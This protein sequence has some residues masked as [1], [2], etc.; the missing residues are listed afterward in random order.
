LL[1]VSTLKVVTTFSLYQIISLQIIFPGRPCSRY[2][3]TDWARLVEEKRALRADKI[4]SQWRISQ[5][6]LKDV[7]ENS[8]QSAFEILNENDLL[9]EEERGITEKYS[10]RGLC[11]ELA[12]GRLSAVDVCLA[13]CHRAAVAQQLVSR[14]KLPPELDV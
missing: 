4:P 9:S 3:M 14:N 8:N 11:A 2:K 7:N 5:D 1:I 6:L 12:S 13:F 10:A